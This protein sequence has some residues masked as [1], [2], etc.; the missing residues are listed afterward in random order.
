M[1]NNYF[2]VTGAH[3]TALDANI[4]IAVLQMLHSETQVTTCSDFPS[5]ALLWIKE[6]EMV[7]SLDEFTSSR[8][9]YGFSKLGD[10]GREDCLC[11]EQDHPDFPVQ[12]EGQPRGAE[13]PKRGPASARETNRLHDLRLFSSYWFSWRSVGLYW[14]I[15]CYSSWWQHSGIRYKMGRSS[16]VHVKNSIRW[17]LGKSVQIEDP[18]VWST[19]NRIGIVRHGESSE[20]I[21]SQLSEVENHGEE[22]HCS[23]T[24]IAKL[25]RQARENRIRNSGKESKGIN[26]LW[27]RKRY[28]LSVERKRP[29]FASRP[30]QFPPR[31]PRLRA[32]ARAHCRHTI[33]ANRITRLKCVEE[34]KH[35]RRR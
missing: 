8:S 18:W 17:Y 22:E 5:D 31:N 21:G 10:A 13:S 2:R 25:W 12:E 16:I 14:F 33:W 28:L 9:V 30:M 19:Q 35:P 29:V 11:S 15:L 3:D 34:E 26:R 24:S 27:R 32:K 1:I 23:E 6:V 4:G 7:D 20:D